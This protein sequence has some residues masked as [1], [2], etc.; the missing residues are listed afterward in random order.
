MR[1]Q[2]YWGLG[3]PLQASRSYYQEQQYEKGATQLAEAIFT[4]TGISYCFRLKELKLVYL[5][6]KEEPSF[7]CRCHKVGTGEKPKGLHVVRHSE[8]GLRPE[9]LFWHLRQELFSS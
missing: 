6:K 1:S 3:E 5:E 9:T 7:L 4:R 8:G 2:G